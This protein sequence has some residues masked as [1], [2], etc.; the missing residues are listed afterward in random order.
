MKMLLH[1]HP[2]WQSLSSPDEL[3]QWQIRRLRHF[4]KTRVIPFSPFYRRNLAEAGF[5]PDDLRTPAD[6]ARLPFTTKADVSARPRDFVLTPDAAV[7]KR[8]PSVV[9]QALTQGRRAVTE[10]LERE[11]RPLM[12]TSTTGRSSQPVPFLL[13]QHDL[14]NLLVTGRRIMEIGGSQ[15]EWRHANLFPYAPHLAFWQTHYAG[16]GFGTFTVGSGGGKVMGTDGNIALV[17]KVRPEVLIGMPT[18]LYHMMTQAVSEGKAWPQ[19]RKI[20]LGGEKAPA[21]LRRK[22]HALA[23]ELG[24][25]NVTVQATYGFTEAKAAW[26]ECPVPV[27][28]EPPGYHVSPEF[29]LVEIIDP[30]TGRPVAAGEP[31]EL[32][33]TALD[34]RGT[35]VLRYRT[36]DLVAGGVTFQPCSHCGWRGPRLLG[37][38]SR[39]SEQ[40]RVDIDKLK[41][42]LVDFN[43]LEHALDDLD[44][45][46]PWQIELRKLN[47]D[48][49][50][51]DELV[52]HASAADA[53]RQSELERVIS[54][55][56][57]ELTEIRP[58]RILWHT[59][60]EL[61]TLHGVGRA[62]KEEKIVDARPAP[63]AA[64]PSRA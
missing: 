34:A 11:F 8:Q 3:V 24:A 40:R 42:T 57:F 56:F 37:R 35:V 5:D 32:V 59:P 55:R 26:I 44:G 61:Q 17:E 60:E 27:D 45:L 9:L 20:V 13:T 23:E 30:A 18:F 58:N 49:F 10:A 64:S 28:D 14:D 1:H 43:A 63:E 51:C 47:D 25:T 54:R 48:P 7:L 41:G 46:G 39:V 15:R 62:M 21:G 6:L 4:L 33:H 36:G 12:L 50:D 31:G 52:V 53:G 29:S 22:L 2:D 16:L 38:I 19:L